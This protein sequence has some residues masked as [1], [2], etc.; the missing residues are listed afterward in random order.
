VD[1]EDALAEVS[2]PARILSEMYEHALAREG[3]AEECCGLVVA[4]AQ[5]RFARVVRCRNVMTQ[6]HEQDPEAWPRDNHNAYFMHPEDLRKWL[7]PDAAERVTA[8]Y[9]SHVGV[10]AYLSDEDRAYV[11]NELFPFPD[12]DQIVLSVHNKRVKSA[13]LFRRSAPGDPFVGMAIAV[14]HV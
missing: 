10:D 9:H 6:K 14:E 13:R 8:V 7:E 11:E 4:S 1:V 3:D 12:A 5:E 2:L